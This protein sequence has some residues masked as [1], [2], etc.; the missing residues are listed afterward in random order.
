MTYEKISEN[1]YKISGKIIA[2]KPDIFNNF[3]DVQIEEALVNII[4]EIDERKTGE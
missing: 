4:A 3:T 1:T 2:V